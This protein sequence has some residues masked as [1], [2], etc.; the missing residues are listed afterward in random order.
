MTPH[1][2]PLRPLLLPAVAALL[3]GKPR[4]LPRDAMRATARLQSPL[5]V[6]GQEFIPGE[7]PGL[8]SIN[9]Y[10]SPGVF[11][12]WPA[13]AVSAQTP[14]QIRWVT[15]A[16]WRFED[17]RCA[18]LLSPLS[19]W[20]FRRLARA[21]GLALMPPMP[22]LP[23]EAEARAAAVRALVTFVRRTPAALVGMA[24]EG[25]DFP[26]GRLGWPPPGA[27][28][29]MLHLARLGL[30]V[31]PVGAFEENGAF[32]LRFGEPYRLE[33]NPRLSG[34]GQDRAASRT[35]MQ[36][37]AALLPAHLRGEFADGGEKREER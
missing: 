28:R 15:T 35:V 12:A 33:A 9:H 23:A 34:A 18:G 7:G 17:S 31:L 3:A 29:L 24:P 4:S 27:G 1:P 36:R 6:F 2:A 21:Y 5:K 16:A 26:G 25:R 37:I 30:P 11:A 22:P 8:V 14:A 10:V 20:M 19:R 32:C 13:V